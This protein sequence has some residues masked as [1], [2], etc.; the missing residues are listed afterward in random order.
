MVGAVIVAGG[1]GVRMQNATP[2]Q[3]IALAGLPVICHAL[4]RFSDS[5]AVDAIVLVVPE[6]DFDRCRHEILPAAGI[7]LPVRLAGGGRH[8]QDSVANGITAMGDGRHD[9]LLVIHDRRKF[10]DV[11]AQVT[12]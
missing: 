12:V 5:G 4:R 6:S 2:K 10:A 3:Y 8:R 9:D 11:L 1:K 7:D